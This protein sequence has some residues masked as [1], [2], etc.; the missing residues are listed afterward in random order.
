MSKTIDINLEIIDKISENCLNESKDGVA[1]KI[2]DMK[3]KIKS[4]RDLLDDVSGLTYRKMDSYLEDVSSEI[5]GIENNVHDLGKGASKYY[6]RMSDIDTVL[7]ES[8]N[9]FVSEEISK[10]QS[11]YMHNG[12]HH[13]TIK[14][15]KRPLSGI[16]NLSISGVN[17][18]QLR[19]LNT[20]IQTEVDS[21]F[22]LLDSME[23]TI[24]EANKNL[25]IVEDFKKKDYYESFHIGVA[26]AVAV[27]ITIVTAPLE[28]IIL[29]GEAGAIAL[30][31]LDA[32]IVGGTTAV[33]S[34]YTN[35][36]NG[37][38][39][40][41]AAVDGTVDGVKAAAGT[42]AVGSVIK[43][44]KSTIKSPDIKLSGTEA[45]IDSKAKGTFKT[46]LDSKG[47]TKNATVNKGSKE[48]SIDEILGDSSHAQDKGIDLINKVYNEDFVTDVSK[49]GLVAAKDEIIDD[50]NYNVAEDLGID[51]EDVTV[52]QELE[53]L[54]SI[55]SDM[56]G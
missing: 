55:V 25:K 53:E 34:T 12:G 24:T 43:V 37:S 9:V 6:D 40:S 16:T 30:L 32:A 21:L 10:F 39:W 46:E 19:N 15:I 3:T 7:D 28:F 20:T 49:E 1:G 51:E 54:I 44:G 41:E 27:G 36:K 35:H 31:A 47:T 29:G 17:Q 22:S 42:F 26:V 45:N 2:D 50:L 38:D 14:N 11:H 18:E 13:T 52:Q 48:E 23:D 33:K 8:I 56:R 4:L 5:D